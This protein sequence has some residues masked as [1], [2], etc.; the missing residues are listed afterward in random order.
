MKNIAVIFGGVSCE[1]DISIITGV[2]ACRALS[3]A[4]RLLPVYI[5]RLG[6]WHTGSALLDMSVYKA[7]DIGRVKDVRGACVIPGSNRLYIKKGARLKELCR[8]HCAVLCTH[9]L[10][11]EDGS[12]QGLL[13]LCHIPYT[14]SGVFGSA[15]GMDKVMTKRLLAGAGVS[16]LN[17][18]SAEKEAFESDEDGAVLEIEKK[19]GFPAIVKPANLGSSIGIGIAKDAA[20]L[21]EALATAF[22][23]D[24]RALVEPA[25]SDFTELNCAALSCGGQVL[26]SALEQ[27]LTVNEILTFDD[28][29]RGGAK[30][31][32]EKKRFPADVPAETAL[33]VKRITAQ[34][35]RLL[36]LGGVVRADF[37][38][39]D[40]RL[41]LNEVNTIPGSLAYYLWRL[42]GIGYR[43]L[44]DIMITQAERD[45]SMRR[46]LKHAYA[47]DVLTAYV[48]SGK[49]IAK[50][51]EI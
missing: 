16:Q 47:S 35:Y 40:G 36:G 23:F 48:P 18:I 42:E 13:Q 21:K 26:T 45:F 22:S 32:T 38:L 30:H 12:L 51:E 17:F 43:E 4:H 31:G 49:T 28:K 6:S 8:I 11:G 14:G 2:S 9:G 10:N 44:I 1:H 5:D 24:L 39:K 27:P 20:E 33:E 37:L 15:C 29:Y 3:A 46:A 34:A 19:I 7:A 41:Y 50:Y 25:L